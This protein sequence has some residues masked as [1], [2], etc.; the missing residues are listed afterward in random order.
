MH[1]PCVAAPH[2]Q[3]GM[4]QDY[5]LTSSTSPLSFPSS[6][7]PTYPQAGMVQDYELSRATLEDVFCQFV[8]EQSNP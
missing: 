1:R 4:V 7:A 3:A 5:E 8:R 2:L 6:S